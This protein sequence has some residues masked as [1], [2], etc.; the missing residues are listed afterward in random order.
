MVIDIVSVKNVRGCDLVPMCDIE[1]RRRSRAHLEDKLENTEETAQFECKNIA[2]RE[3]DSCRGNTVFQAK[4]RKLMSD[5][6]V[7]TLA[8]FQYLTLD[9]SYNL[10]WRRSLAVLGSEH[11][12]D[13]VRNRVSAYSLTNTDK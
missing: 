6:V 8:N 10:S 9:Q 2:N 5:M 4:H 3:D 11:S 12:V 13:G 1:C 7:I